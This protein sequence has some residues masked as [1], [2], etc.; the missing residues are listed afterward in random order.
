MDILVVAATIEE[1]KGIDFKKLERTTPHAIDVHITG[2]GMVAT[3][4][5]LTKKF[6]E[7]KYD[8]AL[9]IGLTGSFRDNI[10]IGDTVNITS[11]CFA[12]PWSRR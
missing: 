4:Y 1:T 6:N 11:D 12:D 5:S 8:L 7:R 3:T 2:V 9:N 10:K